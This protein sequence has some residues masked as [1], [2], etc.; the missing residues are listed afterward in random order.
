MRTLSARALA[1][2]IAITIAT[3]LGCEAESSDGLGELEQEARSYTGDELFDGLVF[4]VGP[5][6]EVIP[7]LASF[8][9]DSMTDAERERLDEQLAD[10]DLSLEEIENRGDELTMDEQFLAFRAN[11]YA[12]IDERD[13]TFFSRFAD[14]MQSGDHFLVADALDEGMQMA[15]TIADEQQQRAGDPT[16][17]A[18][19]TDPQGFFVGL[20]VVVVAVAGAGAA[21]H[22][23]TVVYNHAWFWSGGRDS[24]GPLAR[25]RAIQAI[26]DDLALERSE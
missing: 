2:G 24:S 1:M 26:V 18:A 21:V 5:V 19:A 13:P 20:L 4:G 12:E 15:V 23:H 6:A 16:S 8:R 22:T 17:L 11:L 9:V 7:D 14:A 3:P 10:R 25:E